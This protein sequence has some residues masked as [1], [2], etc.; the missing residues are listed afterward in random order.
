MILRREFLTALAATP[1]LSAKQKTIG[2]AFGTY[3]MKTLAN[4]E[5]FSILRKTG[6]DGVQ[7]CI[8]PGWPTD[9]ATM[10]AFARGELRR[11]VRDSGLAL[12]ALQDTL[13]INGSPEKRKANLERLK[14]AVDLGNELVPSHP[15]L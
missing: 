3:G 12:P 15:P 8:M 4:A 6:Y 2:L 1:L 11:M 7:L 13:A 9:P 14:I 5:A 10:G